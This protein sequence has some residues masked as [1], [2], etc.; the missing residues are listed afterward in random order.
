M[1]LTERILSRWTGTGVRVVRFWRGEWNCTHIL[2]CDIA[3]KILTENKVFSNYKLLLRPNSD[4]TKEITHNGETFVP[5]ELLFM[6][7]WGIS[8][9]PRGAKFQVTERGNPLG[10][11]QSY[12]ISYE[13]LSYG[14]CFQVNTAD[15]SQNAGWVLD[16]LHEWH[17]ACGLDESLWIDLNTIKEKI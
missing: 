3:H 7:Q 17:F 10:Q 11:I 12:F 2:T 6:K 16:K 9:I 4:L 14:M 1:N 5:M 13:N 15:F 8:E